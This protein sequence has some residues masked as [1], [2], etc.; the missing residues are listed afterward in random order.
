M[1]TECNSLSNNAIVTAKEPKRKVEF[2]INNK[3]KLLINKVIVDACLIKSEIS[4][5]CDY[6]FEILED[7]N[8]IKVFYLELKGKDISQAIKQLEATI[9]YCNK[10]HNSFFKECY[11]VATGIPKASTKTSVLKKDFKRRNKIQLFIGTM[12]QTVII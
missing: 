6:L 12:R 8:I 10:Y 4:K 3:S 9:K 7:S 1:I 2:I 5:K 11:I